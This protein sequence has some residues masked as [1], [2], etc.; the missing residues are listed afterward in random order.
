M[1][2]SK[3]LPTKPCVVCG[4]EI[5]WR[6]KWERDWDGVRYCST[7]CRVR[8][9]GAVDGEIERVMMEMLEGRSKGASACPSEIARRVF[10]ES[11][12]GEMERVRSAARRL[13]EAGRV[14]ITQGGVVVDPS[15]AKG[16]VR[17]RIAR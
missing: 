4:R 8:G 15:R 3:T 17:I 12:R 2:G 9:K 13:V 6:K 1:G 14:E 7:A 10:G 5:V 16:A 11:W